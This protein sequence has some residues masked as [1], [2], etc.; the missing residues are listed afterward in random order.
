MSRFNSLYLNVDYFKFGA[1]PFTAVLIMR[2]FVFAFNAV[3]F[4]E[5]SYSSTVQLQLSLWASQCICQYLVRVRPM[6]DWQ[7]NTAQIFNESS[8]LVICSMMFNFT[9]HIP[10]AEDRYLIGWYFLYI[11]YTN[12][13]VNLVIVAALIVKKIKRESQQKLFVKRRK[14][15][16]KLLQRHNKT[17]D[18][19][20]TGKTSQELKQFYMRDSNQSLSMSGNDLS[21][22][23]DRI[24]LPKKA[25]QVTERTFL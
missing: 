4:S 23:I 16:L 25:K 5:V 12:V 1:L 6:I 15:K 10:E 21:I 3:F 7:N 14:A 20:G 2:R 24:G 8:L 19:L 17:V 9:D 11:I 18:V 22:D 13:G